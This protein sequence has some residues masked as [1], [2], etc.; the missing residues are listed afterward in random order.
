MD[1][2]EDYPVIDYGKLI[3]H[4]RVNTGTT[5]HKLASGICSIPYLSK[6]ENSKLDN[7]NAETVTLLMK[8]LQVDLQSLEKY[9][10]ETKDL[11]EEWFKS[12]KFKNINKAKEAY[13]QLEEIFSG[14][15]Q[16][17]TLK[18]WFELIKIRYLLLIN[19]LDQAEVLINQIS[20]YEKNF[21]DEQSGYFLYFKGIFQCVGKNHN[22]GLALLSEAEAKFTHLKISNEELFYHLALTHSHVSNVTLAIYYG[23]KAMELFNRMAYYP[24]SIDC[25][26][27]LAINYTRVQKFQVAKEYYTNLLEISKSSGDLGLTGKVLNNLGYLYSQEGDIDQSIAYYLESLNYKHPTEANYGNTVYG[28]VEGYLSKNESENALK[29]I[30]EG[31]SKIHPKDVTNKL[32]LTIKNL[33]IREDD[34]LKEYLKDEAVP[35]FKSKEDNINLCETYEG[36]ADIYSKNF[37]YKKSSYYYSLSIELRKKL[38]NR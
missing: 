31:L 18:Y 33:E 19:D 12:I 4:Y 35:F 1:I 29:T 38:M 20:E 24:R 15:V 28:L 21:S 22:T 16:V 17:I 10:R 36:L 7:A 13:I 3:Y 23:E 27:I 2:I 32:K 8:R 5:Q 25:Q 6:L 34:R 9:R 37:Q 26:L 30:N 11:L 14:E